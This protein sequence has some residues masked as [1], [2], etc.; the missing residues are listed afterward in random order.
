MFNTNYPT[1]Q[2]SSLY[3]TFEVTSVSLPS[4]SIIS[5]LNSSLEVTLEI[6]TYN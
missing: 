2:N 3:T 5:I 6:A 4:S 1:L